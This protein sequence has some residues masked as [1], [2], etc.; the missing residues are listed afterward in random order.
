MPYKDAETRR[1]GRRKSYQGRR[2]QIL[3]KEKEYRQT[4]KTAK[5]N[6]RL[7]SR[8]KIDTEDYQNLFNNQKG[9]CAICTERPVTDI[10]HNHVTGKVRA[11]LC[12]ACNLGLGMFRDNPDLLSRAIV[13]LKDH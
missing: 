5:A 1:V 7:K 4:N 11:L 6:T 13:Y 12:R 2:Q 8:Y 3:E 9:L 10:D